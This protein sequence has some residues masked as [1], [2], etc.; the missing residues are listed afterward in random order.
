MQNLIT[1]NMAEKSYIDISRWWLKDGL[2]KNMSVNSVYQELKGT[3]NEVS[4]YTLT[5]AR[6]GELEKADISTLEALVRICSDWSGEDL[7]FDD[8]TCSKEL[9]ENFKTPIAA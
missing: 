7:T 1:K 5:K 8:L 4:R 3:E 2:G 9:T 6:D